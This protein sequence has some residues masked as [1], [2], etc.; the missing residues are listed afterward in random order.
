MLAHHRMHLR[1]Q[2]GTQTHQLVAIADHLPQLP[3]LRWRDP[4]LRQATQTQQ[5][6]QI[7]GVAFVV[8]HPALAPV[9][10]QR[11]RQMHVRAHLVQQIDCPIPAERGLDHHL[12][13]RTGSMSVLT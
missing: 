3:Q 2:T 6:D 8:L 9:V 12:R 4:R 11:V 5:V 1:L 13:L 7:I 10:A